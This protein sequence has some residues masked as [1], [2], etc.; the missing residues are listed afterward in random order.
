MSADIVVYTSVFGGYER[1]LR[2]RRFRGVT[3]VAF[4]DTPSKNTT[5]RVKLMQR[6]FDD[7]R[8]ES[9]MYKLLPHKYVPSRYTLYV[10][11]NISVLTH[12]LKLVKAYLVNCDIAFL[13][14]PSRTC[15]Y[16]EADVCAEQGLDKPS[17]IAQQMARYRQAGYPEHNG[18][19]TGGV[20]LRRNT[21]AVARF[22]EL[23]WREVETGSV[24][25]QL[26][27]NYSLWECG[28]K[29]GTLGNDWV[30]ESKHFERLTKHRGA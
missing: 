30:D 26:S 3:N 5:W 2:P 23:W 9:R 1:L 17:V 19:M 16:E 25:D 11:G 6:Q 15:A 20:I 18:L 28:L 29:Y 27:L 12:P 13:P 8:R 24:R 4:S 10:D 21:K 22:N 14:H 7:P